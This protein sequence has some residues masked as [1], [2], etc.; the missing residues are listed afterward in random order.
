MSVRICHLLAHLDRLAPPELAEAWDNV[1]LIVGATGQEVEN[2]LVCLDVTLA[3]LDEATSKNCQVIV[4]HH[5]PIFKPLARIDL[6]EASGIMLR[7]AL[8][9][10]V[11]LIACHT[12]LDSAKGGVS[13]ALAQ[14]LGLHET[15]PLQSVAGRA[16]AGLG[17][18]GRFAEAVPAREFLRRAATAT[19]NA[20][21]PVV[22]TLPERITT[23]A[24]CG[25]SGSELAP[26]ALR[27]GAEVYLSGEIKHST[28]LWA[29]ENCF[30]LIDGGHWGTERLAVDIIADWLQDLSGI[31][32]HRAESEKPAFNLVN[33]LTP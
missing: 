33:C 11:A 5:P 20:A 6:G 1:G 21:L 17:R 25:G 4:S 15:R 19:A 3:A 8:V 18:I 13:D 23:V 22:G 2:V 9:H 30:C 31:A 27:L 24:V 7:A 14:A 12:N 32:I 29:R 10:G 26:L 16:D 28:A